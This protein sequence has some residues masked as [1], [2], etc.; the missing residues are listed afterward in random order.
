MGILARV[1]CFQGLLLP[2]IYSMKRILLVLV[3]LGL[4]TSLLAAAPLALA[5]SGPAAAAAGSGAGGG[6]GN[7]ELDEIYRLADRKEFGA[8]LE[9]LDKFLKANPK[10]A[11]ARFLKGLV[12][13]EQKHQDE[14]IAVF[15][16]MSRDFPDLP[17]PY[18][19]LA[20]LYAEKG[21]LE[22]ARESL[23]KAI[24]THPSYATAHENLGDI[25]A[26]MASEAYSKALSF[27]GAN[28]AA[29]AKLALVTKLFGVPPT[30]EPAA[31]PQGA[32]PP[33]PPVTAGPTR[34]ALAAAQGSAK[35]PGAGGAGG[36]DGAEVG[37]PSGVAEPA[38]VSPPE[39]AEGMQRRLK[40]EVA[41]E[42]QQW[43][44]DWSSGDVNRYL[45]HYAR[46]FQLPS[47]F[48][49]RESWNQKRRAVIRKAKFI[50]VQLGELEVEL[51]GDSK[52]RVSFVQNYQSDHFTDKTAKKLDMVR[53]S[54][55]WKILREGGGE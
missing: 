52:A 41:R 8:T 50:Q 38:A 6:T 35:A 55:R 34:A 2:V 11:Q 31:V 20:V 22:K 43:A 23:Q 30:V 27:N 10:D 24:K 53:E 51:E 33:V 5:E 18:N 44:T 37:L 25:Y 19:N 47:G 17:E 3:V 7:Q 21:D 40:A 36:A 12:L 13:T 39:N 15:E 48:P 28:K 26:K 16:A 45:D 42:V 32:P 29:Q 46:D 14:A 49:S 4:G 1:G 9:R 54:G